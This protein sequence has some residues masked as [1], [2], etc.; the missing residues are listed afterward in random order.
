MVTRREAPLRGQVYMVNFSPT[1]GH[2]QRGYRPAIVVSSDE[3]NKKVGMALVC[4]I[5][6][7]RKGYPFEVVCE[8]ESTLSVILVDQVCALDWHARNF[9]YLATLSPQIFAEAQAK[10]HALVD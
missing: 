5:T 9:K 10:L 7:Q 8:I 1:K 4:P 6:S 2:E 3:Y